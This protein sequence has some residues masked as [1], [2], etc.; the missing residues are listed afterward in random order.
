MDS[1]DAECHAAPRGISESVLTEVQTKAAR[2][3]TPPTV[4]SRARPC[5]VGV[6]EP[7]AAATQLVSFQQLIP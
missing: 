6:Y 1:T 3:L 2:Q 7:P 5:D 4:V